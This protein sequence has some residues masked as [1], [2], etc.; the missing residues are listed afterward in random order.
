MHRILGGCGQGAFILSRFRSKF[1]FLF[2]ERLLL[3]K[4]VSKGKAPS[5]KKKIKIERIRNQTVRHLP[6]IFNKKKNHLV[7]VFELSALARTAL[8]SSLGF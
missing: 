4:L 6:Q 7:N 5:G 2:L 3:S 8:D 1:M